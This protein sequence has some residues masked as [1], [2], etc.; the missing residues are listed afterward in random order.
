MSRVIAPTPAISAQQNRFSFS[1]L[2]KRLPSFGT[3]QR[4][5]SPLPIPSTFPST[6][7]NPFKLVGTP[8]V[9]IGDPAKTAKPISVPIP[10][11]P[12]VKTPVGP[13]SD[14]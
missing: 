10:F 3:P 4:G 9:L 7:Y 12:S 8:P 13:G 11:T 5:M 14:G 2:F 1:A 6:K